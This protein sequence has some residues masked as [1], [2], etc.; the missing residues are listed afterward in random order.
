MSE[1]AGLIGLSV[2]PSVNDRCESSS[3]NEFGK[4]A[5][6]HSDPATENAMADDAT[7]TDLVVEDVVVNVVNGPDPVIED[8]VPDAIIEPNT[9]GLETINE[10]SVKDTLNV[11][12]VTNDRSK[13][14]DVDTMEGMSSDIPRVSDAEP[15]TEEAHWVDDQG[16]T[17]ILDEDDV[18]PSPG[19]KK[20]KKRK[21]SEAGPSE[22]KQK[23]SKEERAAKKARR[24]ERRA[25]KAARRTQRT[26]EAD[27]TVENE[28]EENVAEEQPDVIPPVRHT[29]VDDDWVPKQEPQV[30]DVDEDSD[31]EDVAAVMERRRKAKGKLGLN[32]NRTR[33]GNRR[34]PKN[35]ADVPTINVSL[36]SEEAM[37]R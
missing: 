7:G 31:E 16:V 9:E 19:T 2:I 34:I 28:A 1:T 26:T 29:S 4:D 13:T 21:M 27:E 14:S 23:L 25:R 37:A 36:T 22:P 6:E 24:V 32:E 11:A 10:P 18:I 35:V 8:G 5:V 12:N 17:D 33:I 3:M 15:E 20:S 30:N